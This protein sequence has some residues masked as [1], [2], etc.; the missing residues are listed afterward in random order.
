MCFITLQS[1]ARENIL[2]A[3]CEHCCK[4]DLNHSGHLY[5]HYVLIP[6]HESE[7]IR[8]VNVIDEVREDTLSPGEL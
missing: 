7:L 6:N 3:W 2:C 5:D 1:H 8:L 4:I